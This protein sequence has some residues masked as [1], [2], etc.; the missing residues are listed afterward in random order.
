MI[1]Q[2][3]GLSEAEWNDAARKLRAELMREE[4][5][6]GVIVPFYR[7][8][9]TL[10]PHLRSQLQPDQRDELEGR[11]RQYYYEV[12]RYFYHE[13]LRN[14]HQTRALVRRELPNLR[15]ALDLTV[16][17]GDVET[18]V[19][20]ATN[21]EYFLNVLGRWRERAALTAKID[22]FS[23]TT[24]GPLTKTEFLRT[25][26]QG[27]LLR[28]AGRAREAETVFRGLLDRMD[29]G[30]AYSGLE[31]DCG[32]AVT[33]VC[34][35]R[36][37]MAQGRPRD[38]ETEYRRS[39]VVLSGLDTTLDDVRRQTGAIH[40][41]LADVLRHQ[42][43]YGEA[44][45]HYEKA[46][47]IDESVGGDEGGAA[48]TLGQLG[49]LALMERNYAEARARYR[50]AIERFR[51]MGGETRSEA[52]VWHQLA[53]V[54]QTEAQGAS[55]ADRGHLLSQAETAYG[56]SLRLKE[57][58]GDKALAAT[59]ANQL[60]SVAQLANRPADAERWYRRAIERNSEID[61]PKDLAIHY[62]NLAHLP[63]NVHRTPAADRPPE[64]AG[65]DLLA[66]AETWA[67]KALEIKEGIGDLSLEPWRT[68]NVLAEIAETRGDGEAAAAWRRSE[69]AAFA[70]FPGNW[71]RLAPQWESD[72]QAIA[73]AVRGDAGARE[74]AAE[75]LDGLAQ[76][77]GQNFVAALRRVLD[78]ARDPDALADAHNLNSLTYLILTKALA[79]LAGP[80]PAPAPAAPSS[81][82][83]AVDEAAMLA[84]LQRWLASPDGL[85]AF[86]DLQAR[87]LPESEMLSALVER[88]LTA[89]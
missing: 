12:S 63:L 43:R 55:G 58:I 85:A 70:A 49:T 65:R 21:V 69:R 13:D 79:A 81:P 88:F 57:A 46:L 67:R 17:A 64:F 10:C 50:E 31:A 23:T 36:S 40:T 78:G 41:D 68:Y 66:E 76:A 47:Q 45:S 19:D 6:P 52:I 22:A 87:N 80:P 11:Y 32:R 77:G 35:G 27:E 28:D 5:I 53:M 3:T 71:A 89:Q 33:L 59:T 8:H 86:A 34:L 1:P 83:S 42:G 14:P 38:A 61:N 54:A 30:T 74:A 2:V 25:S 18:A 9:P 72:V 24:D 4:R 73:G 15:R 20:F 16:A 62:N 82:E 29:A 44:R 39:M 60:A 7:F 75:L 37:L 84:A 48:V 26:R 51:A 56:E